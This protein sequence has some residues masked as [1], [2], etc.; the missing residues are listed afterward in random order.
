[1]IVTHPWKVS[2]LATRSPLRLVTVMSRESQSGYVLSGI[3]ASCQFEWAISSLL[4]SSKPYLRKT[5]KHKCKGTNTAGTGRATAFDQ[6]VVQ[7][8]YGAQAFPESNRDQNGE[9]RAPSGSYLSKTYRREHTGT[10]PPEQVPV[11]EQRDQQT[12]IE[13]ENIPELINLWDFGLESPPLT[14]QLAFET[15]V[16]DNLFRESAH[17]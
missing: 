15:L 13:G 4:D 9:R 5:Y 8:Q 10:N 17:V 1:M 2:S 6:V 11:I 7:P 3:Y 14:L 12:V 16:G